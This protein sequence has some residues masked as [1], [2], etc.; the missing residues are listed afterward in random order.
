MQLQAIYL[1]FVSSEHFKLQNKK[2]TQ[3]R[4]GIGNRGCYEEVYLLAHRM[5]TF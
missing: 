2:S 3:G 5:C 4:N 1:I